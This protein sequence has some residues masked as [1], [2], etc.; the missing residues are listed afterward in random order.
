M[1][2]ALL[3]E[4]RVDIFTLGIIVATSVPCLNWFHTCD[5]N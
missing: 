4:F 2:L 1:A 3:N 5:A